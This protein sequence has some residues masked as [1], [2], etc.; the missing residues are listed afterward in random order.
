MS[1]IRISRTI[2]NEQ[3]YH[4]CVITV[5]NP[6]T[7]QIDGEYRVIDVLNFDRAIISDVDGSPYSGGTKNERMFNVKYVYDEYPLID[8]GAST[9]TNLDWQPVGKTDGPIDAITT[10]QNGSLI[11]NGQFTNWIDLSVSS[12]TSLYELN[13]RFVGR[14]A[15]V[16]PLIA[17]GTVFD[18][19]ATPITGNSYTKNGFNASVDIVQDITDVNPVNG[20][21]GSGDKLL[22]GGS[23]TGTANG[24]SV[25]HSLAYAEGST[26]SGNLQSIINSDLILPINRNSLNVI[27][28]KTIAI[29]STNRLR[30]YTTVPT[31]NALDGIY[32]SNVAIIHQ[33]YVNNSSTYTTISSK[34]QYFSLRVRGNAS[35]YP[36]IRIRN[37]SQSRTIYELHQTETGAR[38]RF[39]QSGL[40]VLAYEEITINFIPGQRSVTSNI[41]GNMI[42]FISPTSNFIDWILLGANNSAGKYTQSYDDYRVN[43]IGIHAQNGITATIN[44][45][46]R[47]WSFDANNMFFGTT[48][49]GL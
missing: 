15:K 47:F 22:I 32:G 6:T 34:M 5:F 33:G 38:I 36:I 21:V 35:V 45:T 13:K 49:A 29:A 44:Y 28:S 25:S 17:D 4:G 42:S 14:I 20:Y 18:A 39:D 8:T 10:T 11:I 27:Q 19:Y 3:L 24:E 26:I 43:V 12:D 16:T 1:N 48:K 41:R 40:V 2:L 9:Y 7:L 46:P 23:F 31:T 37:G 30:K